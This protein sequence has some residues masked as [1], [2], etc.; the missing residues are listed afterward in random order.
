MV[1]HHDTTANGDK[2]HTLRSLNKAHL[3]HDETV[4]PESGALHGKGFGCTGISGGEIIISI[5]GGHFFRLFVDPIDVEKGTVETNIK[6][7]VTSCLDYRPLRAYSLAM[8]WLLR[9]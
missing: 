9:K 8:V 2:M 7:I 5:I 6:S 4:L 3:D 1:D